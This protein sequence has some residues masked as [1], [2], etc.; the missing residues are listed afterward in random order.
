MSFL[1]I[2]TS[3]TLKNSSNM[4]DEMLEKKNKGPQQREERATIPA[5]T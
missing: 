5:E 3:H 1:N 4:E 2:L